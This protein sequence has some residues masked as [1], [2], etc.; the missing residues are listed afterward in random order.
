MDQHDDYDYST[1]NMIKFECDKCG[2][3]C[4]HVYLEKDSFDYYCK[5]GRY[6]KKECR[7]PEHD[8]IHIVAVDIKTLL[9]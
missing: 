1:V 8:I 6:Y 5:C 3:I 9:G 2:R 7:I 4:R